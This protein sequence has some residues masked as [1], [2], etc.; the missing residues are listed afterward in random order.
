MMLPS[1]FYSVGKLVCKSNKK[2]RNARR[3]VRKDHASDFQFGIVCR[4]SRS[5]RKYIPTF[6]V[7]ILTK[8]LPHGD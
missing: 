2:E 8:K 7:A 1:F 3:Y 4:Q 6:P 5:I